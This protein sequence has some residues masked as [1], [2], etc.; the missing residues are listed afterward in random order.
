MLFTD[1]EIDTWR[2][3][4]TIDHQ[5]VTSPLGMLPEWHEGEVVDGVEHV[6]ACPHLARGGGAPIVPQPERR[7]K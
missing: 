3:A 1:E 4:T 2:R 5:V 7:R 6:Q